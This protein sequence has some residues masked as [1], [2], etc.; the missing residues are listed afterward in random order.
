[1]RW[2]RS[3]RPQQR[4]PSHAP[5]LQHPQRNLLPLGDP[6][7]RGGKHTCQRCVL[8]GVV[9]AN[10][11]VT[12]AIIELRRRF[13]RRYDP[14]RTF[15]LPSPVYARTK[16][17]TWMCSGFYVQSRIRNCSQCEETRPAIYLSRDSRRQRGRGSQVQKPSSELFAQSLSKGVDFDGGR[18]CVV[19]EGLDLTWTLLPRWE[20][21][22]TCTYCEGRCQF[23]RGR[24]PKRRCSRA[25]TAVRRQPRPRQGEREPCNI[26]R[27]CDYERW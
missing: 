13:F 27:I 11:C 12:D 19:S 1:M 21:F 6:A 3:G 24:S 17:R 25:G 15:R 23:A 9:L 7:V 26:L 2:K 5:G 8:G 14:N 16:R 10:V 20:V 18:L 4:R 22:V